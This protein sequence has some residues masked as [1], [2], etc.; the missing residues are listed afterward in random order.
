MTPGPLPAAPSAA[1]AG[2]CFRLLACRAGFKLLRATRFEPPAANRFRGAMGFRLPASLFRPHADS[3]PS[4]LRD[5]PR[6][7]VI[8]AS[9]L[10]GA[11]FTPGEAFSIGIHLFTSDGKPFQDALARLGWAELTSWSIEAVT[12]PLTP[13]PAPIP[14]CRVRFLTPTELKPWDAPPGDLPPF[15]I[16]AAR[17]RDRVCALSAFYGGASI[18]PGRAGFGERAAA[19]QAAEGSISP[20][21]ASRTSLRTGRTHPLG[22]FTGVVEYSGGLAEFLPWLHAAQWTGVGRQTVWGNG[23]IEVEA[24][25]ATVP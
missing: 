21:Q 11:A 1:G 10:D 15:S 14:G 3:G 2:P 23:Q 8:R 18:Q 25:A 7:F 6:P 22:G 24:T 13:G 17:A 20:C 16:L 19:V 12:V 9:G 4:G 5:R